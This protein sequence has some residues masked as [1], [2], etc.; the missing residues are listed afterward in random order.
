[1]SEDVRLLSLSLISDVPGA[2]RS[3]HD[4]E[5]AMDLYS[6]QTLALTAAGEP[7]LCSVSPLFATIGRAHRE[8]EQHASE[9]PGAAVLPVRIAANLDNE[10]EREAFF[11]LLQ[12]Y[13]R[14]IRETH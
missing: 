11:E 2:G 5:I 8:L 4:T 14:E 13:E 10:D 6:V 3:E 1:M 9:Y 7:A 12:Q